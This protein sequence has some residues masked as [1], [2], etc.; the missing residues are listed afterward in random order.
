MKAF[1]FSLFI[2]I[3]GFAQMPETDIWLVNIV[4]KEGKYNYEK[5]L[6][7]TNRKGYDNQPSFTEDNKGVYFVSVKE[8]KQADIYIYN[9]K[10]K[11]IT[12]LTKTPESEYSPTLNVDNKKITCVVVLKDSS[13]Q[14]FNYDKENVISPIEIAS[15]IPNTDSVG[16]FAWLNKDTILYYKLTNPH[17]LRAWDITT[18][19]DVWICDYPTRAFKKIGNTSEFIYGIKKDSTSVEFRIYNP[20]LRESKLYATY[21]SV[22]ED[23]IWHNEL[24]LIKS[25]N[26][27]LMNYNTKTNSWDILFSFSSL[28]IKKIT[29][30]VFDSKTKQLVIVSNL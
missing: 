21:P 27:D 13:Q 26:S 17:S 18:N 23:F 7:I 5:P 2:S 20:I 25:E 24:G 6:N 4:K 3:Y 12:Q 9:I 22:S 10:K 16:Y 15:G 30:F 28:G 1:L 8:D 11:L 19:K 14:F 29:R